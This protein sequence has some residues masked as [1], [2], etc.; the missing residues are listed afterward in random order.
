LTTLGG[1]GITKKDKGSAIEDVGRE[2]EDA[3]EEEG[4][5]KGEHSCAVCI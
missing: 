5:N 1:L 4:R 2:G 3:M